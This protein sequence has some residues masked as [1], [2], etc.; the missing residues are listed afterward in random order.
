MGK[1]KRKEKVVI[2]LDLVSDSKNHSRKLFKNTPRSYAQNTRKSYEEFQEY[3]AYQA[4]EDFATDY[5]GE[6][7]I[8]KVE[9]RCVPYPAIFVFSD[10]ED[11]KNKIPSSFVG[12]DIIIKS[13]KEMSD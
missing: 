7:G 1:S 13:T 5:L 6:Y 11:S 8:E 10:D 2:G 9:V 3:D 4:A 12:Y